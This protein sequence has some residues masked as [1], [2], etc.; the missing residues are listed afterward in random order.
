MSSGLFSMP[1]S[2]IVSH[3]KKVFRKV[4]LILAV[5]AS[6]LKTS[7]ISRYWSWICYVNYFSQLKPA[8][9]LRNEKLYFIPLACAKLKASF[10]S[11]SKSFP[12]PHVD[13]FRILYTIYSSSLKNIRCPL[14]SLTSCPNHTD[15]LF[16]EKNEAVRRVTQNVAKSFRREKLSQPS[17]AY[18]CRSK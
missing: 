3:R 16:G 5:A 9:L 10:L 8:I 1:S 7:C 13:N 2:S 6:Q 11:S 18:H 12:N 17:A 14:Y 4:Q 15:T